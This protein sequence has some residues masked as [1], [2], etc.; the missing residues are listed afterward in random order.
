MLPGIIFVDR[1]VQAV[2]PRLRSTRRTPA[3]STSTAASPKRSTSGRQPDLRRRGGTGL[4]PLGCHGGTGSSIGYPSTPRRFRLA[5]TCPSSPVTPRGPPDRPGCDVL[6][7]RSQ[8]RAGFDLVPVRLPVQRGTR[9]AHEPSPRHR[10]RRLDQGVGRR[11][12]RLVKQAQAPT[13]HVTELHYSLDGSRLVVSDLSVSGYD[14]RRRRLLKQVACPPTSVSPRF[15]S[16]RSYNRMAFVLTGCPSGNMFWSDPAS[17][18][19]LLDLAIGSVVRKGDRRYGCRL[20]GRVLARSPRGR[21]RVRRM[22]S[23]PA[24]AAPIPSCS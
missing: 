9:S 14:A 1:A 11:S 7:P 6:P 12:G 23:L 13:P 5:A 16:P 4:A 15:T 2:E 24:S 18:L 19:A 21:D 22:R 3:T 17:Q 20:G 10:G 8:S